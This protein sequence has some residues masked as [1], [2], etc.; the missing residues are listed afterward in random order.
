MPRLLSDWLEAY[1]KFAEN[2]EP[3]TSYHMWVG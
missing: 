2:T 1:L 3:P